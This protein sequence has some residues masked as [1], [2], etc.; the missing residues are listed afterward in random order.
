MPSTPKP[1][2]AA[3]AARR[4]LTVLQVIPSLDTGGAE[5]AAIDIAAALAKRGDRAL[6][7]SEGGRLA[8][9]L[10]EAG[11]TLVPLR[12]ASKNPARIGM[13]ALSLIRLIREEKVDIVHAR[14]R[15]P[16]WAARLACRRTGVPFVATF[17]GIYGERN[18]MKGRYNSVMARGDAVIANSEYTAGLIRE[19]YGT[20]KE[21]IVVIPRGIDAS[22]FSPEAVDDARRQ[23]LREA[24][25]LSGGETVVLHLARLTGWKGQKVLVEAAAHP[26]LARRDRLVVVLA[27]DT[28]GREDYRRELEE[29]IAAH[30]LQDRVRIVGHCSDAPAALSLSDVAVTA[31]TEPEAFGRTAIEAASMGVPVVAAALGATMETVLA[32]PRSTA[33]ER[34]GWLV[35]PADGAA[36]ADAIG[37]ALVLEPAERKALAAR[38]RRHAAGFTTDAMQEATLAVYDRLAQ[39]A[40]RM[41]FPKR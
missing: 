14:S 27:G 32:P 25:G 1:A 2:S 30:N 35:P 33:E 29:S 8:A 21:R 15:A 17:H 20:P 31:S 36:L 10:A 34:T 28:Q 5:R 38:A 23:A 26:A 37:A 24:W 3:A 18:A 40:G 16:A 6:V 39:P 13:L 12:A 11:G 41:N 19:R 9:E 22:R 7:V 4:P